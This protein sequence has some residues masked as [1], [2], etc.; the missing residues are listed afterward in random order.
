MSIIPFDFEGA[1]VR[2][3][4]RDG[5][6]WFIALD[7]CRVLDLNNSSQAISRLDDDEK[8]VITNDTLG[9][10]QD[11]AI[12]NESGL[13]SLTL[14]SRKPAAKRFKKWVTSE[15]LPSIRKTGAYAVKP[16][17]DPMVMLNDPGTLRSL[18]A[19]YSEKVQALEASVKAEQAKIE[20]Q[21]PKIAALDRIANSEA[22][23]NITDTAKT[24]QMQPKMLFRYLREKKWIYARPGVAENI[25]YQEKIQAG[26]LEHKLTTVTRADGTE[27]TVTQVRV[28]ARGLTRLAGE[29]ERQPGFQL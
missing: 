27:K 14:T 22:S 5:E 12:I 28:T 13:Y 10:A 17:P 15:V 20:A 16:Q 23:L 4:E 9:G 25:G 18:L 3:V 19:G 6:P 8:G 26:L 2:T 21:A 29:I 11:I 24:L 7:V 1:A